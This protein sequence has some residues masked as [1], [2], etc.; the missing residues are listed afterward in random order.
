VDRRRFSLVAFSVLTLIS[1]ASAVRAQP[2]IFFIR[3]AEKAADPTGGK[4]PDLSEAGKARADKLAEELK[5]AGITAIFVTQ[6]KRTQETAAPLAKAL[7]LTPIVTPAK[8]NEALLAQLHNLKGNA[9]VVGHGDTIPDLLRACGIADSIS[10]AEEDYD[11]LF[12]VVLRP[13]PQLIRLH[14]PN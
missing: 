2:V 1:L 8:D 3:H 4:D 6:F 12:E 9:L 14:Q 11:N 7:G 13:Q 5:D 10:I